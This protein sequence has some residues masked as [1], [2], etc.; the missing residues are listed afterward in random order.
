MKSERFAWR[1]RLSWLVLLTLWLAKPVEAWAD[2]DLDAWLDRE[3]GPWLTEQ[4][5]THPRF[6]GMPLRVSVMRGG[7][8]DPNPDGLSLW[9]AEHLGD[10][11]ARASG[12]RLVA[13]DAEMALAYDGSNRLDCRPPPERYLIGVETDV[14]GLGARVQVRVM[15]LDESSWV[16]GFA[17]SWNGRLSAAERRRSAERHELDWL[18]G[19]RSLPFAAG[20]PDLVASR[21]AA[22]LA[23]DL[24][25][26]PAEDLRAWVVPAGGDP[27]ADA[28]TRLVAQHLARA[29]VLRLVDKPQSA[30]VLIRGE[31]H[32]L[33]ADLRQ[34]WVSVRP[35]APDDGL[36]SVAAAAYVSGGPGTAAPVPVGPPKLADHR[37]GPLPDT[38]P[39]QFRA[40]VP[41]IEPLRLLRMSQPCEPGTC[42]GPGSATE[43]AAVT[44]IDHRLVVEVEAQDPVD[45]YLLALRSGRGL[46]RMAPA[47]CDI[48]APVRLSPGERLRHP[49][50]SPATAL[51]DA[52]SLAVFAIGLGDDRASGRL[53]ALFEELPPDCGSRA[54]NGAALERWNRALTE[55]IPAAA[56]A[57]VWRGMRLDFHR[58]E[59]RVA[60]R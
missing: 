16:A 51:G 21:I 34:F 38:P 44:L 57:F 53:R 60:Y 56:D 15:D 28:A 22:S 35:A 40:P 36:P 39:P 32:D 52:D 45:V 19:Q 59:T 4:M 30:N 54:L 11:L 24:R 2:Q 25:A 13:A 27:L 47:G 23:C 29:G 50:F 20:Q 31:G 37:S 49:L 6:K 48:S 33:E 58:D 3:V 42:S 12:V 9:I 5:T 26:H 43:P 1:R 55:A 10:R 18:R 41:G 7:E 17:R 8:P 14:R 46:V